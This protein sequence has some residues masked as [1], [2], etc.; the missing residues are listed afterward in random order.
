[1]PKEWNAYL[2]NR[3][4][5]SSFRGIVGLLFTTMFEDAFAFGVKS[6]SRNSFFSENLLKHSK[7]N[8]CNCPY[9]FEGALSWKAYDSE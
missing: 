6:L 8:C 1:L 7:K 9:G 3:E 5:F 2:K 4:G